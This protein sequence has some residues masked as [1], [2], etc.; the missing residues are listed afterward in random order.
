MVNISAV[1]PGIYFTFALA[2]LYLSEKPAD[3]DQ[4]I[5]HC[6]CDT[7]QSSKAILIKYKECA[8]LGVLGVTKS[9]IASGCD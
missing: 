7:K 1:P 2:V 9:R 3:F 8:W 6:R 4:P 5:L